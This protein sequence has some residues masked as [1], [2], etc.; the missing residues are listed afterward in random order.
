MADALLKIEGIHKRFGGL[1]ALNDVGL[2][3]NRGEIY[4]LIGPNGAGKTTLF[5]VLTG[6]YQPDEGKFTFNG[7]DLFRQKPHVVV[8]AG[9]AR[10]FQNIRLFGEMTA[11]ENVM[12]GRH[13]RTKAGALGAILRDR[14][15]MAEEKPSV[16]AP[17]SCSTMWASAMSPTNAPAICPT[18]TSAAWKSPAR[19]PPTRPCWRW[20]NR[21]P[22]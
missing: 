4:G 2:T 17:V 7:Q 8:K 15:T 13:V 12:V 1:H 3:I 18:A 19:W 5:N 21:P 20:T 9:I 14:A 22:A 10:T 16:T 6:L 11:L